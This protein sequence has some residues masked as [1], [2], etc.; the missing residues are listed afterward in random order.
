MTSQGPESWQDKPSAASWNLLYN[1]REKQPQ[2]NNPFVFEYVTQATTSLNLI[3]INIGSLESHEQRAK[4][5]HCAS[6][7]LVLRL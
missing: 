3:S 5:R 2:H 6:A 7:M 1:Q 4:D